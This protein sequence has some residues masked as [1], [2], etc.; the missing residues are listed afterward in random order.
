MDMRFDF[1]FGDWY[2]ISCSFDL[3]D[4]VYIILW[5]MGYSVSWNKFYVGGFI[6]EYYGCLFSGLYV[7]QIEINCGFYMDEIIY[8]LMLGFVCFFQDF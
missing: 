8:E 2:G 4:F 7:L 6:I 1:I 3:I 5:C